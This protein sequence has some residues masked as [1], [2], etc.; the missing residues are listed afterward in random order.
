MYYLHISNHLNSLFF[1][2]T[3]KPPPTPRKR[4]QK[5]LEVEVI[6]PDNDD[7]SPDTSKLTKQK[8]NK[9]LK[10]QEAL[11]QPKEK[12]IQAKKPPTPRVLEA[13]S[14]PQSKKT[15][16]QL[17]SDNSSPGDEDPKVKYFTLIFLNH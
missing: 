6:Q 3:Q 14:E 16:E 8:K 17:E 15:P 10:I 12:A 2:T 7:L 11:A 1:Q 5:E 13:E 9:Q 4:K